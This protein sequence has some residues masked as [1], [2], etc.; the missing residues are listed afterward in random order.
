MNG[1]CIKCGKM[2]TR[3]SNRGM[4]HP[5]Y[6]AWWSRRKGYGTF[7]SLFTEAQ[8]ARDHVTAL[9]KA[10]VGY[11]R[12]AQLSGLNRKTIQDLMN[13]RSNRGT[14]PKKVMRKTTVAAIL[15]IPIPTAPTAPQVADRMLVSSLGTRRRIQSLVAYG[16]S[17]ADMARRVGW[18]TPNFAKLVYDEDAQVTAKTARMVD[19]LFRELQLTPGP[20]TRARNRGKA[21]GWPLP[22]EWD[23]DD[24][25]DPDATPYIGDPGKVGFDV[26]YAEMRFDMGLD[27]NEIARRMGL[28]RDALD[29]QKYRYGFYATERSEAS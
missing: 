1:P 11:R 17:Y 26:R 9:V 14:P 27:D 21:N 28:N 19:T 13:G 5:C 3:A 23:E 12:I 29:R 6:I 16:Y 10:G 18:S 7:E 25:D 24:I 20:D 15:A 4:C 8:P 2:F 22:M